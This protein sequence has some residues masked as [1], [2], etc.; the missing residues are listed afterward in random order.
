MR[1]DEAK[2]KSRLSQIDKQ[3][4][5]K[6]KEHAVDHKQYVKAEDEHKAKVC[7]APCIWFSAHLTLDYMLLFYSVQQQE[8]KKFRP[9][10][11]KINEQIEHA[12]KKV[13]KVGGECAV[14]SESHQVFRMME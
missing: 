3:M 10:L 1:A 12:S 4:N 13:C 8:A 2:Q 6:R 11:I 7:G 9:K 5:A 14:A